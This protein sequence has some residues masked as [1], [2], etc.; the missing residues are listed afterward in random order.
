LTV[1]SLSCTTTRAKKIRIP[2]KGEGKKKQQTKKDS[3]PSK[4]NFAKRNVL[5]HAGLPFCPSRTEVIDT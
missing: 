3:E 4:K 1:F 2:E 5:A